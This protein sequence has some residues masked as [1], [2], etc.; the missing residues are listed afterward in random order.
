MENT[1]AIADH[2]TAYGVQTDA[3][4]PAPVRSEQS[5]ETTAY[6]AADAPSSVM[7]RSTQIP[8][9]KRQTRPLKLASW[10][11]RTL[12][13]NSKD[14]PERRTA[15]VGN[16]L[17]R[18]NIDIAALSETRFPDSGQIREEKAGYTFFWRGLPQNDRRIHGV[19]FAIRTKLLAHLSELPCG[20]NERLMKTRLELAHNQHM[21]VISAYAPTLDADDEVK[22]AFYAALHK[23]LNET[24]AADRLVLLGDFNARVGCNSQLWSAIGTNGMGK[25]NANGL[26]LLTMCVEHDLVITN[27]LFRMKNKYKGTWR[28][29]RSRHWHIIDYAIIRRR[30]RRDVMDTRAV[31]GS[32]SLF[33]DHRMIKTELRIKLRRKSR[34]QPRLKLNIDALKQSTTKESL[35]TTIQG[36]LATLDTSTTL[37][38]TWDDLKKAI[39]DASVETLGPSKKKHQDWFDENDTELLDLIKQHRTAFVIWQHHPRTRSRKAE[40]AR[41]KSKL[42]R[43]T[44]ELKNKW[45]KEKAAEMQAL[46][47]SHNSKAFFKAT[48]EIY[49]PNTHG[50]T[51]LRTTNGALVSDPAMI[52]NR[53]REHFNSLLNRDISVDPSIMD[54]LRQ[55]PMKEELSDIP[56]LIEVEKA[57]KALKNGKAPG[58]DGIPAEVLKHGG[59]GLI[60]RLHELIQ[61]I[62]T[63]ERITSDLRDAV[64]VVIFKK[65]DKSICNNY[66]GISLLSTVGKLFAKILLNRLTPLAEEALPDSQSGFRPSRGTVDMIFA[67]RQIQ[68]KSREQRTPLYTTF[69]DL[70]KAF[71]SVHRETLWSILRKYG[72]P[73]KFVGMIRLLHDNM[74]AVVHHD[75][76]STEAFEVNVGVKQGCVIAPTLFSLFM[77]AVVQLAEPRLTDGVGIHYRFDGNIF[78]LRRLQA[79]SKV[80]SRTI[81]ELQ[82]ADDTA[83]CSSSEEGMQRIVDVFAGAYARLGLTLNISKTEVLYQH[84]R[85][86][87]LPTD[88]QPAIRVNGNELPTVTCFKY[89]GSTV[90]NNASLDKEIENRINAAAAAYN[91]LNK[92]VFSNTDLSISTKIKVYNAVILPTLLY[93]CETWVT[94]SKQMKTLEKYHQRCLRRILHIK[95]QDRIT[96]ASVL[97]K[98]AST[99]IEATV[100]LNRLRWVGHVHR[101]PNDRIVKQ[102]YYSQL[103]NGTRPTGAPKKR[104]KDLL[105]SSLKRCGIN[106]NEWEALAADR[107]RWRSVVRSGVRLFESQR[108]AEEATRRER[109]KAAAA[110]A[111][112]RN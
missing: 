101:M 32:D 51:P 36:K 21:T 24:P 11:V 100:L 75:G 99:S 25:A 5:P 106:P 17:K 79:K 57:L 104:H 110:A 62:W 109:R 29:P 83:I 19:G 102:L 26:L 47:D 76:E 7:V 86:F 112:Q 87:S 71:D 80:S 88:F 89:L 9:S 14:R 41:T 8:S 39:T 59:S 63:E 98:T 22:E 55:Y 30:D 81:V 54:E 58:P 15:F 28:H 67:L 3:P 82:Y 103:T 73:E 97:A 91:K 107:N 4:A 61:K 72:C 34:H 1:T 65:G 108:L 60:K 20:I 10:N 92:R 42:Q 6:G 52:R 85:G 78:N 50:P 44:R 69:I 33:T 96:N 23:I 27:T 53:W 40:L 95:W 31:T 49:G 43:R 94:Y 84:Q 16:E 2:A 68:E 74:N 70:T 38:K 46:A 45:W 37:E 35:Q 18:L 56:S 64:I 13:D 12:M 48:R 105:K 93:G 111:A 77:G 90:S 66:R